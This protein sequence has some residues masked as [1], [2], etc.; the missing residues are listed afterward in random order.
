M[1]ARFTLNEA[2]MNELLAGLETSVPVEA[3]DTEA[4]LFP[5]ISAQLTAKGVVVDDAGVRQLA[6]ETLGGRS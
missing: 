6:R 5:R 1:S 2:G 3:G 4:T